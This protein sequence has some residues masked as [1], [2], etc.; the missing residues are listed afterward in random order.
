MR[1]F[2]CRNISRGAKV[3][4]QKK[5]KKKLTS[6]IWFSYGPLFIPSVRCVIRKGPQLKLYDG[7]MT[8]QGFFCCFVC[9]LPVLIKCYLYWSP[10]E[11]SRL[12]PVV[13]LCRGA[14]VLCALPHSLLS[15]FPRLTPSPFNPPC[16]SYAGISYSSSSLSDR[17]RFVPKL[18]GPS[19]DR[20]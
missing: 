7:K 6:L 19:A 11:T 1:P 17:A 5:K 4:Y 18:G 16:M 8:P 9:A 3:Y 14:G 13:Y 10:G 15:F 20:L 2:Q 12:E